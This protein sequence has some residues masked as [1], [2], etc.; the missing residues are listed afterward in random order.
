MTN[1]VDVRKFKYQLAPLLTRANWRLDALQ[2]QLGKARVEFEQNR[3][4]LC[5]LQETLVVQK[6]EIAEAWNKNLNLTTHQHALLFILDA[7]EKIAEKQKHVEQLQRA[8]DAVMKQ[9]VEQ[10]R[11]VELLQNHRGEA[12]EKFCL[13]QVNVLAAETDRDWNARGF[14]RKKGLE[15]IS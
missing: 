3:D 13:E 5:Q 14:L 15:L 6:R 9:C 12:L 2:L 7:Q 1:Q 11:R 4:C 8:L 10:Q